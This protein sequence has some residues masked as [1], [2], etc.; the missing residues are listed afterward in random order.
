MSGGARLALSDNG[1]G[2]R[3]PDT[4]VA[5][6]VRL[7]LCASA[8]GCHAAISRIA[9]SER[10]AYFRGSPADDCRAMLKQIYVS[11][12]VLPCPPGILER[13]SLLHNLVGDYSVD[14]VMPL[15]VG[16]LG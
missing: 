5:A 13:S 1:C 15:C 14:I 2:F 4:G 16:F 3:G 7:Q 9:G 10:R 6:V 11:V 8:Q 12:P